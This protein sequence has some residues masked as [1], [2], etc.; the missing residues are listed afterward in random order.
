M[1]G[2]RET[3]EVAILKRGKVM[4][5]EKIRQSTGEA[6]YPVQTQYTDYSS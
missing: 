4:G 5:L 2:E 3:E 1:C 6:L